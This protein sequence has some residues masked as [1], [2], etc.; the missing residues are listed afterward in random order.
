ML[1]NQGGI[2][3]GLKKFEFIGSLGPQQ[4][5]RRFKSKR[6]STKKSSAKGC[7]HNCINHPKDENGKDFTKAFPTGRKRLH[8]EDSKIYFCSVPSCSFSSQ[9]KRA[10][11]EHY[12]LCYKTH[13]K[14]EVSKTRSTNYIPSKNA[15]QFNF[16]IPEPEPFGIQPVEKS[17]NA[18]DEVD[19]TD[20]NQNFA[21]EVDNLGDSMLPNNEILDD[22]KG[23][24][25]G[26]TIDDITT[27]KT[28]ELPGRI[29]RQIT[30]SKCGSTF[31]RRK[32]LKSHLKTCSSQEN[33]NERTIMSSKDEVI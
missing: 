24:D 29:I 31:S 7:D 12:D 18:Y 2:N 32:K 13:Q 28:Y 8:N 1:Q 16:E 25:I 30:C 3:P 33:S 10:F 5:K 19:I 26:R 21:A 23:I 15:N 9:H 22:N 4:K 6:D 17:I 14:I 27:C 20:N 11:E